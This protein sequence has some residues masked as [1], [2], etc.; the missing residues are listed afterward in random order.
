MLSAVRFFRISASI[1]V[2]SSGAGVTRFQFE[3]PIGAMSDSDINRAKRDFFIIQ[4]PAACGAMTEP[5]DL[6]R[7]VPDFRQEL[8]AASSFVVLR[9]RPVQCH[10]SASGF[11]ANSP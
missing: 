8:T 3:Q 4:P 9:S 7:S 2:L 11:S 10:C 6:Y 5:D 1:A